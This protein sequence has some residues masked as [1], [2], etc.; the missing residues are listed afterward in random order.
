VPDDVVGGTGGAMRLGPVEV[1]GVGGAPGRCG[2]T[3][4]GVPVPVV[5]VGESGGSGRGVKVVWA[6]VSN[7][8]VTVSNWLSGVSMVSMLPADSDLSITAKRVS[9]GPALSVANALSSLIF[10]LSCATRRP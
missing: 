10:D 8:E 5:G 6:F 7:C 3:G 2:V 9:S 4:A 1:S